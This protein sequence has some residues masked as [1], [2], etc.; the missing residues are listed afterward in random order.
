[1]RS[2][3]D[4]RK[5]DIIPIFADGIVHDGPTLEKRLLVRL[6]GQNNPVSC[7]PN[8]HFADVADVEI[9]FTGTGGGNGHAADILIASGGDEAKVAADFDLKVVVE[10]TNRRGGIEVDGAN[11]AGIGD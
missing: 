7:F 5:L 9:A 4:E 1:M 6:G 11:F 8:G 10:N 2:T 3:C